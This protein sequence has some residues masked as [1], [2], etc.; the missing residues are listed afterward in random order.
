MGQHSTSMGIPLMLPPTRHAVKK[1]KKQEQTNQSLDIVTDKIDCIERELKMTRKDFEEKTAEF[2]KEMEIFKHSLSD[3][4]KTIEATA[5]MLYELEQKQQRDYQQYVL[6][7]S[8]IPIPTTPCSSALTS[9]STLDTSTSTSDLIIL[10]DTSTQTNYEDIKFDADNGINSGSSE[11]ENQ[12][13][14]KLHLNFN[15]N[16]R[17]SES[18]SKGN[19]V[20]G[21]KTKD[22]L[23]SVSTSPLDEL[24]RKDQWSP[25]P[26][27]IP[28][29]SHASTNGPLKLTRTLSTPI[30]N[31]PAT[32]GFNSNDM[33]VISD[34]FYWELH[35]NEYCSM[36]D[37]D[38]FLFASHKW[39]L[40]MFRNKDGTFGFTLNLLTSNRAPV[41]LYCDFK[42]HKL[43]REPYSKEAILTFGTSRTSF[44]KNSS[45]KGFKRFMGPELLTYVDNDNIITLSV[46]LSTILVEGCLRSPPYIPSL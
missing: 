33:E 42:A 1:E 6:T 20:S 10:I 44:T 16:R 22:P 8:A 26:S 3:R 34:V 29:T 14:N 28:T 40:N 13:E 19:R 37:S 24:R 5:K 17:K 2:S 31:A 15:F 27:P 45:F 32:N 35:Y 11:D 23:L 25:F 41:E 7:S 12:K 30:K 4:E 9:T 46:S 39:R 36:Y 21:K 38:I 18:S 43:L